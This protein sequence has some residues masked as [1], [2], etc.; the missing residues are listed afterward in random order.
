MK[1]NLKLGGILLIIAAIAG[2]LLGWAH[3]V[4]KEP[5]AKQQ[6]MAKS[7]AMKEILPEASEFK[8]SGSKLSGTVKEAYEGKRS[9]KTVGYA[10]KVAPK[11]Y[12]GAIEIM[13]GISTEGKVEGIKILSH[14]E[15]PGLGAKA[16]EPKFAG[17]FKAKP[18]DKVLQ[19]VKKAPSS[20]NEIEAIT[21]AT[22]TSKAVTVG[23]NEAIQFY[24][25]A[26]KGDAK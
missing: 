25:T 4:T 20:P 9:D 1:E 2:L 21:G 16:P 10:I 5:I 7:Q 12:G 18:I 11:G 23:V 8:L 22:I 6:E 3:E 15:T 24:N 13:V 14:T 17:Q 19:V 26:L